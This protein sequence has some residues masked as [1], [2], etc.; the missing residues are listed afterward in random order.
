MKTIKLRTDDLPPGQTDPG[1]PFQ[2]GELSKG[3]VG[4][5]A[6]G[7]KAREAQMEDGRVVRTRGAGMQ[8]SSSVGRKVPTE[9]ATEAESSESGTGVLEGRVLLRRYDRYN[10]N[11]EQ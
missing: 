9:K 3:S 2:G 8:S 7:N 11:V 5:S 6:E 1:T 10:R 4:Q